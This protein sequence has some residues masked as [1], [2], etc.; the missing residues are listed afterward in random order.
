MNKYV[1]ITGGGSGSRMQQVLP[2][3]FLEI[4]GVPI[5]FYTIAAFYKYDSSIHIIITLPTE[6]IDYWQ[7]LILKKKFNINHQIVPGGKSRFE[8]VKNGLNLVEE[9]SFVAIHDAVRP[10]ISA[11]VI[12]KS[13][14]D[15]TIYKSAIPIIPIVDSLRKVTSTGNTAINRNEIFAIQTPQTFESK[16]LKEAYTFPESP[17]FT[18]DGSVFEN[19]KN[20]IHLISGNPENIK[21]TTPSDLILAEFY[22]KQL[23]QNPSFPQI[24]AFE[25]K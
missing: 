11:E 4:N 7:D 23:S 22:S 13:Y 17:Q 15:A 12:T 9:H 14:L 25:R 24:S 2:K 8:S 16:A 1:I 20:Q 18:D 19:N 5:L 3:Q 6:Y 21:I 10:F